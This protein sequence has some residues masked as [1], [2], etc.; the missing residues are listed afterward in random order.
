MSLRVQ[1]KLGIAL[2]PVAIIGSLSLLQAAPAAPNHFGDVTQVTAVEIPV[3]VVRDGEPVRGLTVKDFEVTEGRKSLPIVGFDVVDL[4]SSAAPT[5]SAT[6]A[7]PIAARRHF[8]FF[9]D[10]SNAE[11]RSVV[12]ARAAAM[13]LVTK[14]ITPTDLVAVATYSNVGPKLVLNFTSDRRQVARAIDHLGLPQLIDR[15]PDPLRVMAED[16]AEQMNSGAGG[17]KHDDVVLETLQDM[18][19]ASQI[20]S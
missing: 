17:G 13:D 18:Q 1:T 12:L 10:L 7:M 9:F 14:E 2:L 6:A 11:P 19:R 15:N 3:Q 16:F 5:A 20:A 8:L 4:T